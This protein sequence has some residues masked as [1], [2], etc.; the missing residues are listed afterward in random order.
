MKSTLKSDE[1]YVQAQR[2][3][4]QRDFFSVTG[5]MFMGELMM[6]AAKLA[7]LDPSK[8]SI[9]IEGH[10]ALSLCYPSPATRIVSSVQIKDGKLTYWKR[11]GPN[12]PTPSINV[13]DPTMVQ[14]FAE[15]MKASLPKHSKFAMKKNEDNPQV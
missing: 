9:D 10:S 8:M 11:G 15:V 7:G 6:E 12:W 4:R 1:F 2:N 14:Q 13:A 5:L 3:G